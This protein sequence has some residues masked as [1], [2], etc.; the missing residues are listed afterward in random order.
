M[1]LLCSSVHQAFDGPTS[2]LSSY[3]AGVWG[4]IGNGDDST[5]Y[6][7]LSTIILL[8]GCLAFLHWHFLPRSPP[9]HSLNLSLHSQQQPSPWDCSTIPKLQLPAT[10]PSRGP[11]LLPEV[12]MAVT[13][14]VWFSCHL[15]C[16]WSVVSLSALNVSLLTQTIALIW[17]LDPCFSSPTH[18]G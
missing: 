18:Q 2:L 14:T 3:D 4:K 17:G 12:C 9:S 16:H 1:V 7:W 13:R 8:Q 15:C 5:H 11:A 10:A 6:V